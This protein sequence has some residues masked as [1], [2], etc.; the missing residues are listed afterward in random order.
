MKLKPAPCLLI[1]T[2]DPAGLGPEICFKALK[3][4][5]TVPGIR[6]LPAGNHDILAEA[7]QLVGYPF[8]LSPI[9]GIHESADPDS[10][11][12][13]L[14]IELADTIPHAEVSA[15]AGRHTYRILETCSAYCLQGEVVGLVTCPINKESL[16]QAGYEGLGH[17]ELLARFAGVDSVETVFSVRGLKIFF[18]SRHLSLRDAISRIERKRILSAIVRMD[19][20]MKMLGVAR[21][22]LGVPGLNPHCGDGGLFGQEEIKEIVPAV[23][24]AR[25]KGIHVSGPIGADSIFHMG[26]EGEFHAILSLYHDQGHIAAKTRDFHQAVTLSL[27]LPY[28]RTSVDH[29]TGFDIAWKGKGNP[30]SLIRAVELAVELIKKGFRPA[31]DTFQADP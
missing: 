15:E 3:E 17:T 4:I 24:A 21:P 11:R 9:D 19:Q 22:R 2:G 29:G 13:I 10:G 16:Q 5:G 20:A 23:E 26:L 18:L 31:P 14:H 8:P 6:L 7:A 1:S 28:L 25:K 27:G 30:V 12:D